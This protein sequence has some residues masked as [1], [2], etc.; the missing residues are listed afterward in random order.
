MQ[1]QEQQHPSP[2]S[3]FNCLNAY[4]QS[5][6]LKGA[7]DLEFFTA[8][9]EGNTSVSALAKRCAASERG[10][11][12]LADYLTVLGLLTKKDGAYGLTIDTATFLDKHSPAYIG[13]A[14]GSC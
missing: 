5:A 10:I 3:I 13:G 6:C 2:E 14:A 9:A 7:I 8:V 12:I 4:Q 11:R 1:Q